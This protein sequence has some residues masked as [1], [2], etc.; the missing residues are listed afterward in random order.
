MRDEPIRFGF[1][2]NW[3][4]FGLMLEFNSSFIRF[5]IGPCNFVYYH[6]NIF[7]SN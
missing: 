2:F 4:A 5:I 7:P 6:N 3:R 1:Y